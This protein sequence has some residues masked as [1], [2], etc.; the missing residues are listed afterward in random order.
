MLRVFHPPNNTRGLCCFILLFLAGC[1][2]VNRRA[3]SETTKIRQTITSIFDSAQA[4]DFSR[5]DA[6]HLYDS[7]FTKFGTDGG[8]RLDAASG[9]KEEH[10]GLSAISDLRMKAD[11]LKIDLFGSTAVASFILRSTFRAANIDYE[12]SARGTL[13]FHRIG[14]SW[15]IV[16]EHFSS[17]AAK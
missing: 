12:R 1:A 10:D 7:R 9:R 15:K 11:D 14:S 6:Y 16:H 13:I 17:L 4:K 2:S 3:D 8:P 5:L